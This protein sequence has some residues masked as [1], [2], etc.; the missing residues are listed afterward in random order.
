MS[1]EQLVEQE[2]ARE[3]EVLVEN[4]SQKHFVHRK[5][6]MTWDGNWVTAVGSRRLTARERLVNE[7]KLSSHK[8][9]SIAAVCF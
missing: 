8:P 5:S 1:V 3:T 7:A 9:S 2:L 6:H 4:L